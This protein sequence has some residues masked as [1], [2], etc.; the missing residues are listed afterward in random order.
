MAARLR[1]CPAPSDTDRASCPV[2]PASRGQARLGS[3]ATL[4]LPA[5]LLVPRALHGAAAREEHSAPESCSRW[6]RSPSCRSRA[7]LPSAR[8]RP[9]ARRPADA[10]KARHSARRRARAGTASSRPPA[11]AQAYPQQPPREARLARSVPSGTRLREV[12]P[13]RP[14]VLALQASA[15]ALVLVPGSLRGAHHG[16]RSRHQV[17][18]FRRRMPM[19]SSRKARPR[20]L[21]ENVRSCLTTARTLLRPCAGC[22]RITA[23]RRDAVEPDA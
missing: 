8:A 10:G 6:E 1:R 23:P 16:A 5:T 22:E 7:R 21:R 9:G 14:D 4:A 19:E 18:S 13:L 2:R 12:A 20:S 17:L 3:R 11:R 15:S